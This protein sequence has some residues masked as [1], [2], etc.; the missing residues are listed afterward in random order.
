MVSLPCSLKVAKDNTAK[1]YDRNGKYHGK[2]QYNEG[3]IDDG[4]L[5]FHLKKHLNYFRML[6]NFL[7]NA[8]QSN[9]PIKMSVIYFNLIGLDLCKGVEEYNNKLFKTKKERS[10]IIDF[11]YKHL[12]ESGEGFRGSVNL[13]L[14][15]VDRSNEMNES[16]KIV[17]NYD[18]ANLSQTY[19]ALCI[20]LTLRDESMSQRIDRFQILSYLKRCQLPNGSFKPLLDIYG[21]PFGENDL[22][23]C[24]IACSIRKILQIDKIY[25][26]EE[27]KKV[28]INI[29][30]LY[31]YV[32]SCTNYE[33]GF[34][35][36]P[37]D[38]PQA[39]LTFC[40]IAILKLINKLDSKET[41]S[42]I[43]YHKLVKWLCQRQIWY[44]KYNKQELDEGDN[45]IYD[46]GGFNGRT[47]KASDTC[48]AFWCSASLK[49]LKLEK[50]I[51]V[52]GVEL[53]LLN[54]TQDEILGGFMKNRKS[55]YC[56]PLH[57]CL[58]VA[59]LKL[60]DS[61]YVRELKDIDESLVIS[62]DALNFMEQLK[63]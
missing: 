22:R 18:P 6:L 46:N 59:A 50:L 47:N 42:R 23:Y 32:L 20:L 8:F 61:E 5:K 55:D 57:S 48:Y 58:A 44:N 63:W 24:L 14:P 31:E 39:G 2:K 1:I 26:I 4:E 28:D 51:N 13:K 45:G 11:I 38:E 27:L 53:Y 35:G 25:E 21:K 49:L 9:D 17:G 29:E 54:E 62:K 3:T 36:E 56:D 41:N 60:L 10:I 7:P 40:G 33:G 37:F 43:N 52:K 15:L 30:N 12:V 34:G 16:L 19:F